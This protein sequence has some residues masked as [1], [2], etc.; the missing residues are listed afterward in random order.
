MDAVWSVQCGSDFSRLMNGILQRLLFVFVCLDYIVITSA[1]P[2]EH[3]EHLRHVFERL[4]EQG[5]IIRP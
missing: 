3:L 1:S 2:S 5:M 4:D